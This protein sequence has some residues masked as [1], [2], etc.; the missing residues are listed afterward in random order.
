MADDR[1]GRERVEVVAWST[2]LGAY[3][4]PVITLVTCSLDVGLGAKDKVIAGAAEGFGDV[5][6]CADHVTASATED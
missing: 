2:V 4:D 1:V 3:F 5:L 6:T